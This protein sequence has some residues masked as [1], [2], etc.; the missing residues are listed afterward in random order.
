M[1]E[2]N[3]LISIPI[4]RPIEATSCCLLSARQRR[5]D[6]IGGVLFSPQGTTLARLEIEGDNFELKR[7]ARRAAKVLGYTFDGSEI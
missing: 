7:F 2:S 6:W 4:Q 3:A 1:L 5:P